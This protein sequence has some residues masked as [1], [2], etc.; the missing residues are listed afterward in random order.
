VLVR[1]QLPGQPTQHFDG[2]AA[3]TGTSF[4]TGHV[5]GR[6]AALMTSAGLSAEAARAALIAGPR[7]HPNYGVLVA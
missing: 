7:W 2:F 6:L 1:L 5:A 4:A 3:W